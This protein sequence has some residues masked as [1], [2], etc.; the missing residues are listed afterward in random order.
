MSL[1][2]RHI[3]Q[4]IRPSRLLHH[5][6]ADQ[7]LIQISL[8]GFLTFLLLLSAMSLALAGTEAGGSGVDQKVQAGLPREYGEV[9]YRF[10]VRW[11][12]QLYIIGMGHRDLIT[13]KNGS[14]TARAQAEAYKIGEWLIENEGVEILLPEGFFKRNP[15]KKDLVIQAVHPESPLPELDMKSLEKT[16]SDDHAYVNVEIL[17]KK[18]YCL[19]MRQVEDKGLYDAVWKGIYKLVNCRD[20]SQYLFLKSDLDYLQGRRTASMLQ[21][22][23]EII[24]NEF[25]QGNLHNRKGLFT[26]GMNHIGDIIKFVNEGKI[27]V[28]RSF[29]SG[30]NTEYCAEMNL[31]KRDFGITII[32]PRTLAED[33]KI[34]KATRLDKIVS[35]F[36]NAA[37]AIVPSSH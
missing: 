4:K 11:P 24:E 17:L 21:R 25:H 37:P 27:T 30:Q 23:P 22:M 33:Q 34:L 7:N 12:N 3:S 32:L 5:P 19:S 28:Y 36:Q 15:G 13:R 2:P 20:N 14:T 29:P 16:L 35:S 18:N 9:I 10:H 8:G 6:L 1:F 26:I 31:L